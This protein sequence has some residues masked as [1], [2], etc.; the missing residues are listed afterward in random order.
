MQHGL[1][2]RQRP[3]PGTSGLRLDVDADATGRLGGHPHVL[4]DVRVRRLARGPALHGYPVRAQLRLRQEAR[5]DARQGP[6]GRERRR[7]PHRPLHHAL[8]V[9]HAP[10]RRLRELLWRHLLLPALGV[11][12]RGERQVQ[13][14]AARRLPPAARALLPLP[15]A[16]RGRPFRRC[17]LPHLRELRARRLPVLPSGDGASARSPG[18]RRPRS[19]RPGLRC[20][21]EAAPGVADRGPSWGGVDG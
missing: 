11:L 7:P 12:L 19:H 17:I 1:P 3:A 18:R 13:R 6:A 15:A 5:R 8:H 4:R 2:L 14:L 21:A 10:P 9:A 16:Q 20:G